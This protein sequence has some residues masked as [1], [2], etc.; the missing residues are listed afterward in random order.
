MS[1]KVWRIAISVLGLALLL[2]APMAV[3]ASRHYMVIISYQSKRL[4]QPTESHTFA[5]FIATNEQGEVLPETRFD[6]SWL[7]ASGKV[8]LIEDPEVGRN[9]SLEESIMLG[10]RTFYGD[11]DPK[12]V[13]NK[14]RLRRLG[15]FSIDA[16]FFAKAWD[17]HQRLQYWGEAVGPT[18]YESHEGRISNISGVITVPGIF[19]KATDEDS[20]H[21]I[22]EGPTQ[23]RAT[24]SAAINC[25]H[26]VS[27]IGGYVAT[28]ER[29]GFEGG[30]IVARWLAF[31]HPG[32]RFYSSADD[33]EAQRVANAWQFEVA[34]RRF[35]IADI[36]LDRLD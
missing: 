10:A 8:E 3:A 12:T 25:I 30:R 20:R 2:T 35:R 7:P 1:V 36:A 11:L 34:G 21:G 16:E 13:I 6:I 31:R 14:S 28:G 26:A 19:Y 22:W 32:G 4:N 18:Y 27:D 9:F 24:P 29:R 15:P 33:S 17:Q 23:P 5:S